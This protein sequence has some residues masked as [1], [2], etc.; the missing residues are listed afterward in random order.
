MNRGFQPASSPG[1][2][3]KTWACE[4]T[5][6]LRLNRAINLDFFDLPGHFEALIAREAFQR[7]TATWRKAN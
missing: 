3:E 5:M 2:T 4:N 1:H 7:G 6:W